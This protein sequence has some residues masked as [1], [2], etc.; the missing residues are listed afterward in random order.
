MAGG[1][2]RAIAGSAWRRARQEQGRGKYGLDKYAETFP[3]FRAIRVFFADSFP[4]DLYRSFQDGYILGS[5]LD[6]HRDR[7]S[8]LKTMPV[9]IFGQQREFLTGTMRI[10]LRCGAPILQG[11]VVSRKNFYFRLIIQ[12]PLIDPAASEDNPETLATAMQSY[13]S[14]IEKHVRKYPDHIS[15]W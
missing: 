13:A 7:G 2:W 8:H 9:N 12:G 15:R 3:E 1:V 6:V 4:R 11:F 14:N 5:A 10:A